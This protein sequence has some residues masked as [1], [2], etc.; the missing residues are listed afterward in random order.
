[1]DVS[2]L[3]VVYGCIGF[4]CCVWMYQIYEC[5]GSELSVVYSCVMCMDVL[6]QCGAWMCRMYG[7]GSV[8]CGSMG[9]YGCVG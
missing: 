5:F 9:G 6:G 3:S 2:E 8:V 7:C 1:M 4:E